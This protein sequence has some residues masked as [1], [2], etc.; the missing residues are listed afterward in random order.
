MTLF[1]SGTSLNPTPVSF[2]LYKFSAISYPKPD[3]IL[4]DHH[5]PHIQY[6]IHCCSFPITVMF[7]IWLKGLSVLYQFLQSLLSSYRFLLYLL[8]LYMIRD[9]LLYVFLGLP[10]LFPCIY[11][12]WAGLIA[13]GEWNSFSFLRFLWETKAKSSY[14]VPQLV[15]TYNAIFQYIVIDITLYC[16]YELNL[17]RDMVH[18]VMFCG[19]GWGVWFQ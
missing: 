15:A 8:I 4:P 18:D 7:V 11:I 17:H 3:E 6:S 9:W 5:R 1:Q 12:P 14:I 13:S 2:S 16:M 10:T 19:K